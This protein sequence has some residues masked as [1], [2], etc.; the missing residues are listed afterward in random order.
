MHIYAL[1]VKLNLENSKEEKSL[2]NL[3]IFHALFLLPSSHFK[4]LFLY[5]LFIEILLVVLWDSCAGDKFY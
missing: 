1:A 5:S 2:L 4:V 3:P